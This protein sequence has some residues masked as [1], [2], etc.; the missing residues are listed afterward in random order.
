MKGK[1]P[2]TE[3]L[4]QLAEAHARYAADPE[5]PARL[6]AAC[7]AVSFKVYWETHKP[8]SLAQSIVLHCQTFTG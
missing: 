5:A 7:E 8:L 4:R 6:K 3:V 1:G 2:R